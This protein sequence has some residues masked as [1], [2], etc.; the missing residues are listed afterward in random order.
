MIGEEI[1]PALLSSSLI[2]QSCRVVLLRSKVAG[3]YPRPAAVDL[4]PLL[5]SICRLLR[6]VVALVA[7][8][9]KER[10]EK[11]V[12]FFLLCRSPCQLSPSCRV[13]SCCACPRSAPHKAHPCGAPCTIVASVCLCCRQT[14]PR[15]P[16]P[17]YPT[18]L[19]SD[20]HHCPRPS[21]GAAARD[22]GAAT[23]KV[24]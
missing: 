11:I 23:D 10:L 24:Q 15:S 19:S 7:I 20:P 16:H 21:T 9:I 17:R 14:D 1:I 22:N 5:S 3:H 2:A 6:P 12:L 18:E 13:A 4:C 8:T